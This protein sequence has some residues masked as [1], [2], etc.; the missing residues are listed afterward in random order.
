MTLEQAGAEV[1]PPISVPY[2][3]DV[4]RG[5]RPCPPNRLGALADV[6]NLSLVQRRELYQFAGYLPSVVE[7]M[8]LNAPNTWGLNPEKLL[9][10]ALKACE[11]A[12]PALVRM[13][14]SSLRRAD[15]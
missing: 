4:E 2:L 7:Q 13:A 10:V 1:T 12:D 11:S 6:Y 8:T 5:E 15:W 9:D 3:S 14:K